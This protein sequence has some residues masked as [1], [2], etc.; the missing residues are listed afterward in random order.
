MSAPVRRLTPVPMLVGE[1]IEA[2]GAQVRSG[3]LR[4][5]ADWLAEVGEDDAA[6]LLRTVD[7][8]T[9]AHDQDDEQ[10]G[11]RGDVQPIAGELTAPSP[12]VPRAVSEASID[13]AVRRARIGA[14]YGGM[15][16]YRIAADAGAI[17]L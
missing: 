17:E 6:Y 16:W 11:T 13:R 12:T 14:F 5:A 10:K 1:Q 8:P 7:V 15:R 3:A 4:D 9:V 2:F